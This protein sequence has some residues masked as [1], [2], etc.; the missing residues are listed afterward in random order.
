MGQPLVTNGAIDLGGSGLAISAQIVEAAWIVVAAE[1]DIGG[2]VNGNGVFVTGIEIPLQA[3]CIASTNAIGR[4]D[5]A[6][7]GQ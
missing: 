7:G 1:A 5:T 2:S 6:R 3:G 4:T